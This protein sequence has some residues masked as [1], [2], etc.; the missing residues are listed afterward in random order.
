MKFS[1]RIVLFVLLSAFSVLPAAFAQ[2]LP[3]TQ[4]DL[5]FDASNSMWGQIDGKAKIEIAREAMS[6]LLKEFEPK[7]N[8]YLGLRIYGHLN[9]R[10]DNSVLEI[11]IG[12]DNAKAIRDKIAGIKP[13]GKTPIAYSLQMSASDFDKNLPGKKVVILV[14]DGLESCGGNPCVAAGLLKKAGIISK[15]HVVGF[16][17]KESELSSLDCIAKPFNGKVIGANNTAEL[18]SAFK[19]ISK[20][21]VVENNLVVKGM[22]GNKKPVFMDVQVLRE[23]KTIARQSGNEVAF[24][25]DE[26][27][28]MIKAESQATGEKLLKQNISLSKIKITTVEFEFNQGYL[29]LKSFD[30]KDKEIYTK[31]EILQK[32]K[33]VAEIEG[34]DKVVQALLPGEYEVRAINSDLKKDLRENNVV[35]KSGEVTETVFKFAD[36]N[37]V[38]VAFDDKNKET[39]TNYTLYKSGTENEVAANEGEGKIKIV[40]PPG[41]YDIKAFHSETRTILWKKDIELSEGVTS[42]QSFKF[43]MAEMLLTAAENDNEETYTNFTI[44]EAGTEKEIKADEGSGEI[45]LV[46]PPGKYDI[47]AY[48]PATKQEILEKDVEVTGETPFRKRFK[49][50]S[51]TMLLSCVD[52]DGKEV[53][54]N[55]SILRS[56]TDEQIKADEGSGEVKLILPPGK[57]DIKA[58]NYDSR[59]EVLEKEIELKPGS[60]FK[61]QFGF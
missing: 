38:L 21:V 17:L 33:V 18:I 9:K 52:A 4:I 36:A 5:I 3:I 54:T 23:E 51:A 39:Y 43:A 27:A 12:K 29:K 2:E 56:G 46:V 45:K 57:Y 15:I 34:K 44:L 60:E 49:F 50:Y 7:K 8:I 10:C 53:Y 37:F 26:A 24:S 35:I 22:D 59:K 14:T 41:K 48:H 31:Y 47:K 42:E 19:E 61:K 11:K 30:S 32:G 16:G 58:Y 25:L 28:Y 6:E 40:L 1:C 55:F 20:A 13:L